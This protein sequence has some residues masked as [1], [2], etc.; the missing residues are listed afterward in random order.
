[1]TSVFANGLSIIHKGDGLTHTCPVPDVCKTPSPAGPVPIP[2]VNVAVGA[3][4]VDGSS[5]VNVEGNPVALES[6]NIPSSSGDEAGSAG[7]VISSK[8]KGK[9]TWSTASPNVK[10]DG[11]GVVRFSDVAQHNGNTGNTF[12]LAMGT[13]YLSYPGSSNDESCPNCGKP[14]SEHEPYEISEGPESREEADKWGKT[15]EKGATPTEDG[16]RDLSGPKQGMAG[17]LISECPG[18]PEHT[19]VYVAVAG[20]PTGRS[21]FKGWADLAAGA[22]GVTAAQPSA[23]VSSTGDPV[24]VKTARGKDIQITKPSNG[25]HPPMQCAAQ[26]LVQAALENGCKPTQMTEVFVS[27]GEKHSEESCATCRDNLARMLCPN[28]GSDE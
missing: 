26:K 28:P 24:T 13:P 11:K 19:D 27:G 12:T 23:S 2:Y 1:M 16:S 8:N 14:M 4:L 22:P 9:L 25:K 15:L 18:P 17:V 7:G 5:S 3:E 20:K 10:F 6:S 21:A